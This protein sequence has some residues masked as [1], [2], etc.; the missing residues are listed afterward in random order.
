MIPAVIPRTIITTVMPIT[1]RVR[2]SAAEKA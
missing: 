2:R 1:I